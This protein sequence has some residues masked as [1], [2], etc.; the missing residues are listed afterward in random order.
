MNLAEEAYNL[1]MCIHD[2]L[3]GIRDSDSVWLLCP[4][5]GCEFNGNPKHGKGCGWDLAMRILDY[6]KE[7]PLA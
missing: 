4:F 6:V 7:N 3:E 5:C 2:D 1:A